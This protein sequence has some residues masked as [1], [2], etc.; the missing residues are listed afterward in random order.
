MQAIWKGGAIVTPPLPA[1]LPV[2][3]LPTQPRLTDALPRVRNNFE[4]KSLMEIYVRQWPDG[5]KATVGGNNHG[6]NVRAARAAVLAIADHL[7]VQPYELPALLR[8]GS[9]V[10]RDGAV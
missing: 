2:P 8:L 1:K 4:V 6:F 10:L 3:T 5:I 9:G 7:G